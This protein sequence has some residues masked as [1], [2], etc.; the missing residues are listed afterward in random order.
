MRFG[1]KS[2]SK[3]QFLQHFKFIMPNFLEGMINHVRFTFDVGDTKNNISVL[4]AW[5]RWT[6]WLPLIY[7]VITFHLTCSSQYFVARWKKSIIVF[8][9]ERRGFHNWCLYCTYFQGNRVAC[10]TICRDH[11]SCTSNDFILGLPS[12]NVV[13]SLE[14]L[15]VGVRSYCTSST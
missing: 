2:L 4:D 12:S 8:L 13:R 9:E 11:K 15:L 1:W 3:Y 5:K 14:V 10:L 6:P 7:V